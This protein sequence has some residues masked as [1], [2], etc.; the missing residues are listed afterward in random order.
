MAISIRQI[1]RAKELIK[2]NAP[3]RAAKI[4]QKIIREF[5]DDLEARL[6]F[7][8]VCDTMGWLK[9]AVE[10]YEKSYKIKPGDP[11]ILYLFSEACLMSYQTKRA[12]EIASTGRELAPDDFRFPMVIAD[13]YLWGLPV[14]GKK[15]QEAE[16]FIKN[17]H[18][19]LD[20]CFSLNPTNGEPFV[21][22]AELA[23]LEGDKKAAIKYFEQAL[24]GGLELYSDRVDIS[25]CRSILAFDIGDREL[26]K[27]CI[28]TC[29]SLAENWEGPHFLKL[30]LFREHALMLREYYLGIQVTS[31]EISSFLPEYEDL[32][33]R[34]FKMQKIS[35]EVRNFFIHLPEY[36]SG[37]QEEG[38]KKLE[39]ILGTLS[40]KLPLCIIFQSVKKPSLVFLLKSYLDELSRPG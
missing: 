14:E 3:D 32:A 13:G 17:A 15:G 16:E 26:G 40:E 22:K 39:E 23:L 25:L 30:M 20:E 38:R 37:R 31:E 35:Q 1:N 9:E 2:K 34:G 24:E 18:R 7:G 28:E 6:L 10:Q 33:S 12:R 11:E 21:I 29:L 4:L 36:R 8:E 19:A 5:P 27:K